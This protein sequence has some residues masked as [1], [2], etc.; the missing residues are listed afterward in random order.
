M[1]VAATLEA[2]GKKFVSA[3]ETVAKDTV[4]VIAGT[5]KYLPTGTALA[6]ALFPQ[7]APAIAAGSK[8]FSSVATLISNTVIEVEQK[9]SALPTAL[10]G[11]QKLADVLQIVS[12][13][14]ISALASE[15]I[16]ADAGYVTSLVNSVV[17][18]LNIPTV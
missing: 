16:T 10:T 11:E 17:A 3:L 12:S 14:V 7:F 4:K 9:S 13:S 1:T 6:E 8:T 18:F 2:D 15:K 5:E